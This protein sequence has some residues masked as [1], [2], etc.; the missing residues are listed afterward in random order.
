MLCMMPGLDDAAEDATPSKVEEVEGPTAATHQQDNDNDDELSTASIN[1][2][3]TDENHDMEQQQSDDDKLFSIEMLQKKNAAQAE[4]IEKLHQQLVESRIKHGEEAYWLRLELDSSRR[5]KEAAEDRMTELY[6]DMQGILG[7]D[8]T[9]A[10]DED[11]SGIAATIK[12]NTKEDADHVCTEPDY[13]IALQDR[14]TAYERSVEVL[15]RQIEMMKTSSD[16]VVTSMKQEMTDFMEE[17]TYTERDLL[18]Q[19]SN[20]DMVKSNLEVELAVLSTWKGLETWKE[21]VEKEGKGEPAILHAEP[22]FEGIIDYDT[23]AACSSPGDIQSPVSARAASEEDYRD[24]PETEAAITVNNMPNCDRSGVEEENDQANHGTV[25]DEEQKAPKEESF[26]FTATTMGL[27]FTNDMSLHAST[28]AD[29][30]DFSKQE[31]LEPQARHA[32]EVA[33]LQEEVTKWKNQAERI[34]NEKMQ[35]EE[36]LEELTKDLMFTK[37]STNI[38]LTLDKVERDRAE[39]LAHLDRVS[40]LWDRAD[41]T[42]QVIEQLLSELQPKHNQPSDTNNEIGEDERERLLSTLET[43]ALV[44][45]QIKMSLMLV[46]LTFRNHLTRIQSDSSI[47]QQ[48]EE[49]KNQLEEVRSATLAAISE[50][51]AKWTAT[52]EGL[53][54]QMLFDKQSAYEAAQKQFEEL[55]NAHATHHALEQELHTLKNHVV[56]EDSLSEAETPAN[57]STAKSS[58]F[59]ASENCPAEEQ[60]SKGII[61]SRSVLLRLQREIALAVE[62]IQEKNDLIG[63]LTRTVE[64]QKVLEEV[65]QKELKRATRRKKERRKEDLIDVAKLNLKS[66][67]TKKSKSKKKEDGVIEEKIDR[68]LPKTTEPP[69]QPPS[70]PNFIERSSFGDAGVVS[71][72]AGLLQQTASTRRVARTKMVFRSNRGWSSL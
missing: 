71:E 27:S 15:S 62:R 9:D 65:L 29:T 34:S 31:D 10:S 23:D 50:A 49:L 56:P 33:E 17:K 32:T 13:V 2:N 47:H 59:E 63:R 36:K 45:G 69:P 57:E 4:Q 28:W 70:R 44:H 64:R 67:P 11:G 37:A 24:Q 53:E 72:T 3:K 12:K 41:T 8:V 19:I 61:V 55:Q 5:E 20:L 52:L 30:A 38:A 40:V 66:T 14:L 42:I 26:Q 21:R 35:I 16:V 46:E 39:T 51:E 1:C 18:N 58:V 54:K 7:G 25:V 43:V 22:S 6:H 60:V 68:I 48:D